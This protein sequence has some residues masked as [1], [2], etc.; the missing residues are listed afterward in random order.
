[1]TT[2]HDKRT[3]LVLGATG[4][5]GGSVARELLR[6]GRPVRGLTRDP[7][8]AKAQELAAAGA[9]VVSGDLDDP[10]SLDA[11]L[12]G[13]YG[14]YS[15]Q[16]FM[17]PGG[18]EA[19]ERQGRA[20]ADAA[21]RAGVA[22][23]VYGSVGGAERN[24]GVP[25]FDSKA[26]IEKHI[27]GLGLP[28]TM[29][30]PAYFINNFAFMGPV[31]DADGLVVSLAL[32]P[33]TAL[34]MIAPE[35]IG[36]FAAD[37]FDNPEEYIG[38]QLELASEELTGPQLAEVFEK[39]SGIPTRFEEQDLDRLRQAGSEMGAMFAWFNDHGYR[40]D[41]PALRAQHPELTTLETWAR[42]SWTAP[43]AQ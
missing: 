9:E 1:M 31:R 13:V 28:A 41:I 43:A 8:S 6:R 27:V 23:F 12:S 21:A 39:V 16:T 19:E 11:A 37:A 2:H 25:H 38:S 40:A 30:R 34:Q 24:S 15:V 36:L 18:I 17:G 29:L 42:R 14:V 35:D 10:R 33:G 5:Q 26:R 20:V 4:N 32:K 22:H 3:I 7:H